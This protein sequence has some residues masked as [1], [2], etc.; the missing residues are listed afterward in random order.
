MRCCYSNIRGRIDHA[1]DDLLGV[2]SECLAWEVDDMI[3]GSGLGRGG[4]SKFKPPVLSFVGLG[5]LEGIGGGPRLGTAEPNRSLMLV[6]AP[7]FVVGVGDGNGGIKPS[8]H[9]SKAWRP[10]RSCSWC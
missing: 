1:R 4:L 6:T 3:V 9:R 10:G 7:S 2:G 5:A 8:K